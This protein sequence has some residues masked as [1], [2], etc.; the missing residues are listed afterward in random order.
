MIIYNMNNEAR[1]FLTPSNDVVFK[2]LFGKKVIK[3]FLEAV[4]NI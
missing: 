4:L 2:R 3:D 1:K